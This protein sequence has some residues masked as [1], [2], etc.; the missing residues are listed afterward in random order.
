MNWYHFGGQILNQSFSINL[1]K[2][3][4]SSLC[5]ALSR[6]KTKW[7]MNW[8]IISRQIQHD[9]YMTRVRRIICKFVLFGKENV[10]SFFG[11]IVFFFESKI[12]KIVKLWSNVHSTLYIW[13]SFGISTIPP[14]KT[15][16]VCNPS[17]S[18]DFVDNFCFFFDIIFKHWYFNKSTL[19]YA[20]GY[21]VN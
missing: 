9:R 15:Y 11:K 18:C 8:N 13:L 7:Q 5:P 19:I 17:P 3:I 4:I 12:N 16:F 2:N 14:L 10:V 21:R 1:T 20:A 6:L